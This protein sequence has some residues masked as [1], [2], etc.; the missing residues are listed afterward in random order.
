MSLFHN[1]FHNLNLIQYCLYFSVFE[2]EPAF[3]R[4][5]RIKTKAENSK[6]Y[7]NNKEIYRTV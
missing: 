4:I 6:N 3:E 7:F 5:P 1:P 2:V